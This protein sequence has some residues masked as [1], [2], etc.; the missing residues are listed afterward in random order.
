MNIWIRIALVA[1][2][3]GGGAVLRYLIELALKNSP[4]GF[5]TWVIN[6]IGCFLIGIFGG[7]LVN[8]H[9][10]WSED[11]RTSFAL[12]TMTGF[13]GGFSTFSSFTLDS[14]KYYEAGHFLTW[15]IFATMTLFVGLFGCALGYYLG[16][17]I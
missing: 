17:H 16:K 11:L 3:G 7:W 9:C 13:C 12:L 4:L 14:V 6:S 15:V 8:T 5:A 1:I 10:G 2:A